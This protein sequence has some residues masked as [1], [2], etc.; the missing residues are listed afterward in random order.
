VESLYGARSD[1]PLV[2]LIVDGHEYLMP[3]E[4][5]RQIAQWLV[6]A[7]EAAYS[8]AFLVRFLEHKVGTERSRAVPILRE[9]RQWRELQRRAGREVEE[10]D[11]EGMR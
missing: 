11:Q 9:F 10:A 8:D 6:E 5:A 3:P 4:K 7:A 2:K 1:A